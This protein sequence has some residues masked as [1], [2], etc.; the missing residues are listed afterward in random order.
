MLHF[1]SVKLYRFFDTVT[2]RGVV[3]INNDW[4]KI[5]MCIYIYIYIYI[6][7]IHTR[8]QSVIGGGALWLT[9]LDFKHYVMEIVLE[10][11]NLHQVRLHEKL[12]L[13]AK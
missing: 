1:I 6:L 3:F 2:D 5:C 11:P 7:Y 4:Y 9:L 10:S 13:T 12:K 8:I